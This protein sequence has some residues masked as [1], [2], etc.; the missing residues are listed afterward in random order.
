MITKIKRFDSSD[1]I[2]TFD[3]RLRAE[4]T[5]AAHTNERWIC[6]RPFV[7]CFVLNGSVLAFDLYF[8]HLQVQVFR[9]YCA[10]ILLLDAIYVFYCTARLSA[11]HVHADTLH[12][13]RSKPLFSSTIYMISPH[14]YWAQ[15]SSHTRTH[16][17]SEWGYNYYLLHYAH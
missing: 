7:S 4:C 10:R 5:F 2:N 8:A 11:Y 12:F 17:Q 3:R 6:K 13:V 15:H 9:S 16:A 14:M 1:A